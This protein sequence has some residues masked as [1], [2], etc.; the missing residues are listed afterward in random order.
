MELKLFGKPIINVSWRSA[1]SDGSTFA[2][3]LGSGGG[4]KSGVKVDEEIALTFSAVW[5]C[6]RILSETI[7]SLP[8]G[9]F[10]RTNDGRE[11]LLAHP[12]YHLLHNEPNQFMTS[13]MFRETI[14]AFVVL[15]GNGYAKIQYKGDARIES[16][17]I[18]HPNGVTPFIASDGKLY[19]EVRHSDRTEILKDY[20]ML[21]IPGLS[22]DG[23]KG[24]APLD[25]YKEAVGLGKAAEGFGAEFFGNGANTDVVLSYPSK[26]SDKGKKNLGD[27][28]D[29]KYRD[30]SKKTMVLEEGIKVE[31]VTIP[32]EQA[33]FLQTRKFQVNEIARI[34]RVPPHMIADLEKSTNNNIEHQGIDFVT[35]TMR[36]WVK[37]F[38]QEY[39][40]KL[41][42][43]SEKYNTFT[44][45]NLDALL[46]GDAEAR[47]KIM[48]AKFT[49]GSITSNEIRA[50]DGLNA[51]DGG[52]QRYVMGNMMPIDD[53][54]LF[55]KTEE[56]GQRN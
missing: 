44:K 22:F 33:Q 1:E 3:I 34:F 25:V 8:L 18:L 24:K 14:M 52:D 32:P 53:K 41:F 15:W 21:H 51:V 50:A 20:E 7:A 35:H 11:L 16:L 40:R 39:D 28:F 42:Y 36:P 10:K 43:E 6:V 27:S 49:T 17:D 54:G 46:R 19:Y 48:I 30:G 13:F 45:H 29:K 47:S 55:I 31:R 2:D 38:E 26:L 4:T 56:D 9:V 5:A 12:V 23:I 37:R